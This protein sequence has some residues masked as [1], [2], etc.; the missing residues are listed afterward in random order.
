[1][2][3]HINPVGGSVLLQMLITIVYEEM[4][5]WA[6]KEVAKEKAGKSKSLLTYF[7]KLSFNFVNSIFLSMFC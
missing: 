4:L 7:T 6:K 3:S 5:N 1:M 2:P